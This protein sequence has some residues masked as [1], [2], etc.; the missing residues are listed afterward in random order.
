[1][2]RKLHYGAQDLTANY[3]EN[4]EQLNS[5]HTSVAAQGLPR[6]GAQPRAMGLQ[7]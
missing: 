1:M 5:L 6:A 3:Q 7:R 2:A 4:C